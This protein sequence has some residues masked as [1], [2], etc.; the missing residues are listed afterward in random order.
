MIPTKPIVLETQRRQRY[1]LLSD[2]H[3]DNPKCDRALLKRHLDKA[4]KD[5]AHVLINGDFFCLMQGKGDPRRSKDDIRPEHN[6]G[7]YLDAVVNDALEWFAPYFGIIKFI[8]YGNHE[9]TIIK[10]QETDILQR[11]V[12]LANY[13]GADIKLGGYGGWLRIKMIRSESYGTNISVVIKY[14]H[15]YGGGGIVTKGVIQD[16][17]MDA[18]TEGADVIWMGHVHELYHHI[19]MVESYSMRLN[20]IELKR[21]HHIRTASYKE[22]YGDGSK[23]WHIERGAPPKPLGGYIMDLEITKAG[24]KDNVPYI[25]IDFKMLV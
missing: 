10:H 1:Y 21:V 6:K 18:R 13:K 3:W 5:N 2:L 16:Q 9:T 17:R 7:N 8:S 25:A 19:T 24:A 20:E 12:T 23:G 15:G 14:L 11:F 4:L 22:E